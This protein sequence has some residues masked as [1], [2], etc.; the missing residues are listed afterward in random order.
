MRGRE[1]MRFSLGVISR[2]APEILKNHIIWPNSH[3]SPI[4]ICVQ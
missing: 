3:A 2:N 4:V 1:K